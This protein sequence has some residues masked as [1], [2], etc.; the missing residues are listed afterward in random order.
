MALRRSMA[1]W[2]L[3]R[4]MRLLAVMGGPD[5]VLRELGLGNRLANAAGLRKAQRVVARAVSCRAWAGALAAFR[6]S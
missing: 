2:S 6:E 3:E 1:A 5:L 4:T